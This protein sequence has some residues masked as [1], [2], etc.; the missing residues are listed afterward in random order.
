MI[1]LYA[2]LWYIIG[3]CCFV[4]WITK[5]IDITVESIPF[6]LFVGIFGPTNFIIGWFLHGDKLFQ[7][8]KVLFKK[9][10]K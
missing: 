7:S 8:D 4:F 5:D 9:R 2:T 3:I 10:N 6:V 1:I